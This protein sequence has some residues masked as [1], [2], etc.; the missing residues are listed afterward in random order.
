MKNFSKRSFRIFACIV[1]AVVAVSLIP[2]F[3][4]EQSDLEA[5]NEALQ[6]QYDEEAARLADIRANITDLENTINELDG[7]IERIE[8]IIS[9]YEDQKADKKSD[10]EVLE[11]RI[12]ILEQQVA[13]MQEEIDTEYEY[14]KMRI[15]FMY[16]NVG[17]SY[18]ES[19][20]ASHSFSEAVKKIQ[21]ILEITNYDRRQ[22]EKIMNMIG[23][24]D[25]AR[26]QIEQQQKEIEAQIERIGV[27]QDAQEAQQ[28]LLDETK[29]LKEEEL[30]DA[31]GV[32]Y[33]IEVVLNE[34]N[35]HISNNKNQIDNLIAQYKAQIEAQKQAEAEKAAREAQEREEQ[36]RR[37]E[38][39]SRRQEEEESRRL[40]QENGEETEETEETETTAETGVG[41]PVTFDP[42]DFYSNSS[43]GYIWPLSGYKYITSYFGHRTDV[44]W[45]AAY[46]HLGV[47]IYAPSGT[48][49]M[50][51]QSGVVVSSYNSYY[52]GN[53]MIIYLSG[54]MY[55]EVHHMS[56]TAVSE[57]DVVSQGQTIGYVGSTGIY[58][59]GAHLH[60]GI[61]SS[62]GSGYQNPLDYIS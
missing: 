9:D 27:L 16:E 11:G 32:A 60:I 45:E 33:N 36:R 41:E 57:G 50:A 13:K 4:D 52:T 37:E 6:N 48:P 59:T 24:L 34:I 31:R 40:A 18:I 8:G 28:Q 51:I 42:A 44:P 3:A 43:E 7:E 49:I 14:M 46:N 1:A 12:E 30:Q 19:V 38:E 21:Y 61:S 54:G 15:Q 55:M 25:D 62:A 53:T 10:I 20:L 23:E 17:D 47:D 56:S 26:S 22:A 29:A 5:E 35:D 39:E 58:S 2:V